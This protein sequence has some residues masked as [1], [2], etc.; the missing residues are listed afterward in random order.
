[1]ICISVFLV[2]FVPFIVFW[3]KL[4]TLRHGFLCFLR[5]WLCMPVQFTNHSPARLKRPYSSPWLKKI[6]NLEIWTGKC[7]LQLSVTTTGTSNQ[8]T[9]FEQDLPTD[10]LSNILVWNIS[11]HILFWH[12]L[13]VSGASIMAV[14]LKHIRTF[15]LTYSGISLGIITFQY[16]FWHSISHF[17]WHSIGHSKGIYLASY[18]TYKFWQTFWNIS[19]HSNWT[20]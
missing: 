15:Y 20:F 2:V 11:W 18:L 10:I 16:T 5:D 3:T 4:K 6:I 7:D 8:I 13:P 12:I 1:M 19:G 17:V 9:F 14:Y